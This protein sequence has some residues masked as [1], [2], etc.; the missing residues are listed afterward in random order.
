MATFSETSAAIS[1]VAAAIGLPMPSSKYVVSVTC[2]T[3][4]PAG[5]IG[6]KRTKLEDIPV[7]KDVS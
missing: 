5:Q 1:D 2:G 4:V 7:V 3:V 6:V